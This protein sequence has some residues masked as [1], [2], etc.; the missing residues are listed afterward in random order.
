MR[1]TNLRWKKHGFSRL[2]IR[3]RK[4]VTL[5]ANSK[6]YELAMANSTSTKYKMLKRIGGARSWLEISKCLGG[7]YLPIATEVHTAR[8]L[9][10]KQQSDKMH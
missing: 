9:H 10:R 2:V 4:K 6:E 5:L 3:N 7:V 8:D 1:Y